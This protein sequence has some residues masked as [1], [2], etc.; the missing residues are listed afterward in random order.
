MGLTTLQT[1]ILQKLADGWS[2]A[3]I[4]ESLG[5]SWTKQEVADALGF[6]LEGKL[7]EPS[8]NGIR[9]S[10][11]GEDALRAHSGPTAGHTLG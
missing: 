9:L 7:V 10:P 11:P 6:L 3:D 8:G 5:G 1:R 4:Q 2:V